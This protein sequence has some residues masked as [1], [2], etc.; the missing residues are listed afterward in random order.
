MNW[1][2]LERVEL[3]EM[4]GFIDYFDRNNLDG[5]IKKRNTRFERFFRNKNGELNEWGLSIDTF[6]TTF[7]RLYEKLNLSA[8]SIFRSANM[9]I[10][11]H[12]FLD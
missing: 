9:L 2:K 7:P 5:S 3:I 6:V 4:R 8:H 11:N 1:E 12:G 10:F